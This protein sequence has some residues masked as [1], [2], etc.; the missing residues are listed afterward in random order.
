MPASRRY[1]GARS[2]LVLIICTNQLGTC[3]VF[4]YFSIS[5]FFRG[6]NST[7]RALFPVSFIPQVSSKSGMKLSVII[8]VSSLLSL[9]FS[10]NLADALQG[11]LLRPLMRAAGSSQQ[12][13]AFP[14]DIPPSAA[15]PPLVSPVHLHAAI[16]PP[17]I[18]RH[19]RPLLPSP[20]PPS[21]PA[22]GGRRK[23][24]GSPSS[25]LRRRLNAA[26]IPSGTGR[27]LVFLLF[28][29]CLPCIV[30]KACCCGD[31]TAPDVS[32]NLRC[33]PHNTSDILGVFV[34]SPLTQSL[35]LSN[36]G[37]AAEHTVDGEVWISID[38]GKILTGT[39]S[40]TTGWCMKKFAL[41]STPAPSARRSSWTDQARS[42]IAGAA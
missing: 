34:P 2:E 27:G 29:L 41:S 12:P 23:E 19:L 38:A 33:G 37:G 42:Y 40:G 8:Y 9:L 25:P 28:L 13:P 15:A 39:A 1:R 7:S 11:S 17:N 32:V 18:V 3:T 20:P 26:D 35:I 5:F 4:L 24:G 16:V 10:S 31:K 22:E 6:R 30:I 14:S 36:D 21:S